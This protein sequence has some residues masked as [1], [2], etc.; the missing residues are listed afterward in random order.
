M[1]AALTKDAWSRLIQA[2]EVEADKLRPVIGRS[3]KRSLSLGCNPFGQKTVSLPDDETRAL[4]RGEDQLLRASHDYLEYINEAAGTHRRA[5]MLG[6]DRGYVLR[7]VGDERSVDGP[8]RVPGPG[9]LLSESTS[10]TN[11]LATAL[12]EGTPVRVSL[13]EHYIRPFQIFSCVGAPIVAFDGATTGVLCLAASDEETADRLEP[14]ILCSA[15]AI[16]ADLV[17]RHLE[18][19]MAR[20]ASFDVLAQDLL[21]VHRFG[22]DCLHG[23]GLAFGQSKPE[24]LELLTMAR[25]LVDRFKLRAQQWRELAMSSPHFEEP[26]YLADEI[27]DVVRLL[28]ACDPRFAGRPIHVACAPDLMVMADRKRLRRTLMAQLSRLRNLI[29]YPHAM[30]LTVT[31]PP[32][33][34][35]VIVALSV[36]LGPDI[37]DRRVLEQFELEKFSPASDDSC[38]RARKS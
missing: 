21:R 13:A 8:D 36:A 9:A 14:L 12:A 17:A 34:S 28:R 33:K 29:A 38:Y 22:K 30:S 23:A 35:Y 32:G 31:S 1:E 25:K 20:N 19:H 37:D 16:E 10:G 4:Q 24:P 3:W 27:E 5:V 7:V 26:L 6:D 11:G 15:R 2:G 18:N